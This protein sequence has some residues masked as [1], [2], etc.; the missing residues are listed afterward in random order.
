MGHS[1][2]VSEKAIFLTGNKTVEA[3]VKWIEDHKYDPDFEEELKM[4]GQPKSTLTEEEAKEKL[5]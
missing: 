3:A 4:V 5:K 2:N 1:K